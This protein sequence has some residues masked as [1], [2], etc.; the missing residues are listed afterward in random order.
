[1]DFSYSPADEAFRAEVRAW[2]R[3]NLPPDLARKS[4][5]GFFP[6]RE[7]ALEWTKILATKGWS[8]PGWPVEH[9]GPPWS[10]MQ[11]Y[12]FEEELY[13]SGAPVQNMQGTQLVGPVIYTFGTDAQKKRFL[14][15]IREGTEYWTQGFS[16]PN[17]G[18]DLVSLRTTA[19]RD[20][21]HF[22]VN[23]QKIWTSQAQYAD[24]VFLLVRTD[25]QSKPQNGISFLLVDM[26]TP[27]LTVRGIR[28][29]DNDWHL[30][31]TFYDNVRVPVENLIGEENKGWGYT[32]F[33]LGNERAYSGADVPSI[34]RYLQRIKRTAKAERA[35]GRALIDDPSFAQRLAELELEAEALEMAILRILHQGETSSTQG[36]AIGSVL[37]VR[38]TELQ[39]KLGALLVEALGEY[40]GVLYETPFEQAATNQPAPGPGYAPGGT[41]E[42]FF[43]RAA[44]IYGGSNEIQRNIIAKMMLQL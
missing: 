30:N 9:G 14:P 34:K 17:A 13:L 29:I 20:G 23:G 16:E 18:S 21:D 2:L 26:K 33:L 7:A 12:I 40:G 6:N 24:W 27:G 4:S 32:K 25:T 42:F 5:T 15:G 39:Q 10:P 11:R 41:S 8:V 28:S 31:E 43:R 35:G 3:D 1:M 37:K 22:V 38:G 44:T 36:W 19:I